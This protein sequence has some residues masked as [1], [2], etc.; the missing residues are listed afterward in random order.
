MIHRSA[1]NNIPDLL[2]L[3]PGLEVARLDAHSWAITSRGFNDRTGNKL[4]VLID[5]RSVYTPLNSGVFWDVQDMLLEDIERIEVIRGP[6]GTLWGANAVNGVINIITKK[7]KD[8]QGA[9]VTYGGGTED[10]AL[11][12]ARVGGTIGED[13]H[14]RIYGKHKEEAAGFSPDGAQ[15]AWRQGRGGFRADWE[16]GRAKTDLFTSTVSGQQR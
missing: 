15:D 9:L 16:P 3:V 14:Y 12:G 1:C 5:G 4:L 11:G 6:G 13:L 7:A 2:R 10:L 8:T